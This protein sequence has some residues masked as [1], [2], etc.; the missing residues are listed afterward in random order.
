MLYYEESKTLPK[1]FNEE[2]VLS[3]DYE[4]TFDEIRNSLLVLGPQP[5]KPEWNMAWRRI[6]VDNLE[7]LV[8][9]LWAVGIKSIYVDGSFVQDKGHPG[10][11]DGCFEC[12]W[13]EWISGSLARRLNE[14]APKK[15]WT[16]ADNS[17]RSV[18]GFRTAKLP[19]WRSY[20]IELFPH[21][22]GRGIGL[23]TDDGTFLPILDA[24]R[25]IRGSSRRKGILILRQG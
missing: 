22:P 7:I 17:R 20:R 25:L 12:D 15:I 23:T 1:S 16:W 13:P 19:M 5:K 3:Q 8:K 24:F 2:A 21:F 6:L 18:A 11:I 4:V 10:D 14:A 9:Q